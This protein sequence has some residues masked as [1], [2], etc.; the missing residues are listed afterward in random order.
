MTDTSFS[1]PKRID[2]IQALRF[3]GAMSITVYHFGRIWEGIYFD[4][5]YA[6]V[7]F[8]IVSGFVAMLSTRDKSRKKLFMTRRLVKVL[9]L[10]WGL[11]AATFLAGL[12]VPSVIGYTPQISQLI[13]SLLF[14]PFARST[15]KGA[16]AVRPIVGLG[17]TLQLEMLFYL[18]FFI[19]QRISHKYRG[20]T[21]TVFCAIAALAGR[22][23][24]CENVVFS[25]YFTKTYVWISFAAGIIIYCI[26]ELIEKKLPRFRPLPG[27]VISLV[28]FAVSGIP[29]FVMETD[30]LYSVVVF[31]LALVS[32]VLWSAA[33][34]KTPRI[35]IKCGDI[36]FS[37]YLLH[38][39]IVTLAGKYL[40]V[41]GLSFRNIV[42]LLIVSAVTWAV[43]WVCWYIVENRIS[44][45]LN[46]I[47]LNKFN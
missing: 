34:L 9:P 7:L 10:Y 18:F 30:I 20:I 11:T 44:G 37:Y 2:S 23:I 5:S 13:K 6:V 41:T 45:G 21:A 47:I 17:H 42:L 39:Y 43:S 31:S 22:F 29:L 24:Y 36:S 25:F 15:A 1:L 26:F 8:Y 27:A 12:V 32:A 38:Y 4:F 19:A 28:L 3:F 46:R 14:I 40:G 35:L 16:V 33:G